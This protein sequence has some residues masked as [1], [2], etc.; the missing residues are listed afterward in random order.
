VRGV[1]I[2]VRLTSKLLPFP[3]KNYGM[4]NTRKGRRYAKA[5]VKRKAKRKAKRNVKRKAKRK[6]RV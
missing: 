5:N 4:Q 2:E 3:V 6:E 1:A